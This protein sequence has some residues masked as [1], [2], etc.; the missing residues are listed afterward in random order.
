MNTG[1]EFLSM[2]KISVFVSRVSLLTAVSIS[3]VFLLAEAGRIQVAID[4]G[5]MALAC[6]CCVEDGR[7]GRLGL[8]E[9]GAGQGL[10]EEVEGLVGNLPTARVSPRV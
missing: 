7:R 9:C 8:A 10:E 6:G 2:S 1:G 5:Q 3:S 4:R